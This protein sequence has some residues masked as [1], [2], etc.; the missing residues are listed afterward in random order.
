MKERKERQSRLKGT[1]DDTCDTLQSVFIQAAILK[2]V[3]PSKQ[4]VVFIQLK[5]NL[6]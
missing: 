1:S 5:G 3:T 2:W 6:P 4:Q